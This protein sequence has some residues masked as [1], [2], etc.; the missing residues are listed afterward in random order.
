MDLVI[1]LFNKQNLC[2]AKNAVIKYQVMML[3][4]DIVEKS[5]NL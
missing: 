4:V 5:W 2:T 3:F 1:N